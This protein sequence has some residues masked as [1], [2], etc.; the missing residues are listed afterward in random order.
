MN[1]S[2]AASTPRLTTPNCNGALTS[3]CVTVPESSRRNQRSRDRQRSG[4]RGDK[5]LLLDPREGVGEQ[6][7]MQCIRRDWKSVL[8]READP[9][10]FT[11]GGLGFRPLEMGSSLFLET[12]L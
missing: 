9:V 3:T 1:L 8:C 2:L 6:P 10:S 7:E 4:E 5:Y 11:V 12:C